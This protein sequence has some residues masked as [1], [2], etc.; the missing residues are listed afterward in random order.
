MSTDARKENTES[1]EKVDTASLAGGVLPEDLFDEFFQ[2]VQERSVVLD[3]A[4]TV[5]MPREKMRV[6][7]IGVGSRERQGQTE[8]SSVAEADVTTDSIPMDAEKG[9]I[10]WSLTSEAVEDAVDDVPDVVMD[11]MT[12]QFAVDTE[13]LALNGDES[14][15][16]WVTQ[17]DGWLTIAAARGAPTYDHAED[18]DGDGVAENQP[19]DSSLFHNAIQTLDSKYLRANPAFILNTQQVQEYAH[20]LTERNS[21]L[22][23]SVLMGDSDLNPFGY[24]IIGSP[25]V[26]ENEGMFTPPR[27]LLYGL[28]RDVEVD[29]LEESDDIHEQDL[30]AKYATRVRDDFQVEDENAFVHITGIASPTA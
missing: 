27:N 10:Y 1:L 18:T 8:G 9:A 23:D 7:K 25:M 13:D 29:V 17:N 16:G 14:G 2:E 11:Q 19:I 15:S 26:P 4:R 21:G 5:T 28:Y 20:H 24:D 22:G 6:P 30:F 3:R 12:Q